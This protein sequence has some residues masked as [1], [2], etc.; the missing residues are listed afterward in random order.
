MKREEILD[1]AG[2]LINGDRAKDYGDALVRCI[3]AR[4]NGATVC[5]LYDYGKVRP[6][7]EDRPRRLVDRHLWLCCVGR[8]KTYF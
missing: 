6:L 7:D 5:A 8:R 4:S 3:R 2:D 1:T